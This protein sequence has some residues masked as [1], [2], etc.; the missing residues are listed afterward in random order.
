MIKKKYKI[1][2]PLERSY[3]LQT[4]DNKE[5]LTDKYLYPH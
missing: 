2:K 5:K 1:L 4:K 3:F